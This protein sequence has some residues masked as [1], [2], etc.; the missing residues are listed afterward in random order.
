[1]DIW[2]DIVGYL[3][4]IKALELMGLICGLLCVWFL[5]KDHVLTWPFGIFYVLC[6]FVVFYEAKLY[7]DLI[8][9]IFF[10]VM[11][12]YGW[13]Y[14]VFGKPSAAIELPI[15]RSTH[16][17]ILSTLMAG[18][19]GTIM[20][21]FILT[22]HTD[23]ALPYWD[24]SVTIFS[25][26]AMWLTARKKIENWYFW[27]GIDVIATGVYISKGIYF[28]GLLYGIYII[29]AVAGLINWHKLERQQG[30]TPA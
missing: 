10:L 5:I 4:Q 26:V 18:V 13:Y 17:L 16:Y 24:S 22:K 3:T 15:T 9:H 2:L 11:N 25:L 27:I 12:I 8:L 28:Y 1:M 29:L 23:A 21:G 20:L 7:A 30:P 14:W 19:L 6:S